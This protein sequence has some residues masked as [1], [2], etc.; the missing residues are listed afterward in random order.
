[1]TGQAFGMDVAS[2]ERIAGLRG[3]EGGPRV[4][5]RVDGR[6]TRDDDGGWSELARHFAP[7]GSPHASIHHH[8]RRGYRIYF[9]GYGTY[10]VAADG[11]SIVCNPD[12]E[13]EPWQWHQFLFAQ[14]LPFAAVLSGLEP[15]HASA[16]ALGGRVIAFAGGSGAG[17]SSIGLEMVVRGARFFTDDVLVVAPAGEQVVC[18]GGPSLANVRDERLRRLAERAS[19]PFRGV[20]GRTDDG[21]RV[22]VAGSCGAMP[23]GALYLLE[24]ARRHREVRFDPDVEPSLL[25]GHTFNAVV[26]TPERLARQLDTCARIAGSAGVFRVTAPDAMPA[27]ELAARI[28]RHALR[29]APSFFHLDSMS[30]REDDGAYPRNAFGG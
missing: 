22:H 14:A 19:P 17:K 25:L 20:L 15:L 26:R 5:V 11:S 7:D 16:V 1:M 24:R 3:I 2:H 23:L 21:V 13:L 10:E 30:N 12:P 27:A 18:H 9:S 4:V 28:E 29:W 6:A 8:A